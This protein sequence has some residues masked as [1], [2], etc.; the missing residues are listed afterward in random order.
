[1]SSALPKMVGDFE[2]VEGQRIDSLKIALK[3]LLSAQEA[4]HTAQRPLIYAAADMVDAIDHNED[5]ADFA[6]AT[7]SLAKHAPQIDALLDEQTKQLARYER[8][9]ERSLADVM[10]ASGLGSSAGP[11]SDSAGG[12]SGA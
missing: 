1:M 9:G 4:M 6:N 3:K 2:R 5:V 8:P 10:G 7:L 11:S 12:G